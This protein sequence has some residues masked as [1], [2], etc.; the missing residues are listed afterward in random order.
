MMISPGP[1][2][3]SVRSCGFFKK[4]GG[5]LR[6]VKNVAPRFRAGIPLVLISVS[7]LCLGSETRTVEEEDDLLQSVRL[8]AKTCTELKAA[9]DRVVPQMKRASRE[10]RSKA[11]G[12]LKEMYGER[13]GEG[14]ENGLGEVA[15]LAVIL[16]LAARKA[17]D[18]ALFGDVRM[19]LWQDLFD[20]A[21]ALTFDREDKVDEAARRAK[22]W[23]PLWE[24]LFFHVMG[25][26]D[27][28][29]DNDDGDLI[30]Q[31]LNQL[32][33]MAEA[34]KQ[35]FGR[36]G[37]SRKLQSY[38]ALLEKKKA[39]NEEARKTLK[40]AEGGLKLA[41]D[42]YETKQYD[43]AESILKTKVI[44]LFKGIGWKRGWMRSVL[45]L[46][47]VKEGAGNFGEIKGLLEI[48]GKLARELEDGG[49]QREIEDCLL[50]TSPSPRDV[51]ESR[52]PSSA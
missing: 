22:M 31:Y 17:G 37:L 6:S 25:E 24:D 50:Y 10:E 38:R 26:R 46:A 20:I 27:R 8:A 7:F 30:R 2:G 29:E 44:P 40:E 51:E 19:I 36:D 33:I 41:R 14:E 49:V 15:R 3:A 4:I 13:I 34:T 5:S 48:A 47:R 12:S 21:G 32:E 45:L 35:A 11:A 23:E 39:L 18:T 43:L 9:V 52:M 1:G 28:A 42:R 16:A